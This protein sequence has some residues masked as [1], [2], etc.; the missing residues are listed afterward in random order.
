M[1]V[2]PSKGGNTLPWPRSIDVTEGIYS[3]SPELERKFAEHFLPRL[4]F[5]FRARRALPDWIEELTQETLVAALLAL[6]AGRLRQPDALEGFVLGIARHQLA[7][8]FRQHA[9]RSPSSPVEQA[10]QTALAPEL[11]LTVRG[12]FQGLDLLS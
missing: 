3:G 5:L 9:K 11:I 10:A 1:P 12:E 7:E 6:R 4:K 2:I 8:A